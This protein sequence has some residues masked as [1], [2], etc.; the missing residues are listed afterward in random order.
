MRFTELGADD[1]LGAIIDDV[2]ML[3]CFVAGTLIETL[4]GPRA[5]ET[6]VI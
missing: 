6:L 2:S 4:T 3:I 5:V 1:S